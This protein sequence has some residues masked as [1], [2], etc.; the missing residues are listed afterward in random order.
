MPVLLGLL[1]V[2]RRHD[3]LGQQLRLPDRVL[4]VG[5]AGGVGLVRGQ[6]RYRGVVAGGPCVVDARHAHVRC[7]T[8]P[9]PLVE[10]KIAVSQDRV[11]L[12]SSG[13]DDGVG[14]ERLALGEHHMAVDARLEEGLETYLDAALAQFLHRVDAHLVADLGQDPVR[15]V[16]QHPAHIPRGQLR[17]VTDGVLSHVLQLAE[18][19]RACEAAPHEDEREGPAADRRVGGGGRDV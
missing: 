14:V 18:C 13:P 17:V 6:V 12:H 5:R 19:F 16:D 1:A 7:G 11:G 4:G 2:Q 15:G 8:D 3:V 10:R 9:A